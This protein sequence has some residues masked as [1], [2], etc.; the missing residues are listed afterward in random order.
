MSSVGIW[1]G[2]VKRTWQYIHNHSS[3][4]SLNTTTNSS[5]SSTTSTGQPTFH[6]LSIDISNSSKNSHNNTNTSLSLPL[7]DNLHTSKHAIILYHDTVTG[8]RSLVVDFEE[9]PESLGIS[10]TLLGVNQV[11]RDTTSTPTSHSGKET[12]EL[13]FLRLIYIF[14]YVYKFLCYSSYIT[15]Y[16]L[17]SIYIFF[18]F[19]TIINL[20]RERRTYFTVYNQCR[21]L[22]KTD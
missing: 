2:N 12:I 22:S 4:S 11:I 1:A 21:S 19:I 18:L 10:S 15:S 5:S 7:S 13:S 3:S 17:F 6:D 20:R 8:T 16:I 9:V 14:Q